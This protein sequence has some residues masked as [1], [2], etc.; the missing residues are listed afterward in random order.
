MLRGVF[1]AGLSVLLLGSAGALPARADVGGPAIVG[2]L[3]AQRAAQGVPAG[4]VESPALSA[5]CAKHNAYG[6]INHLL[7]HQED[8]S[9]PGYTPEG[10]YAAANSVLYQGS[11]PWS[12]SRNPFE[13]APIH[14]HQL[15]APRLDRMGASENQGYGCATTFASRNRPP[16]AADVTYTYPGNGARRWPS[17]QVASESPYTPGQLVGIP[18][19]TRTGPYLYVMFDGPDLTPFDVA[20]AAG[21]VLSGPEGP[22]SVAV[23][24]NKTPGLDG[25]LPTGMQ[26]I[27]RAPLRPGATYTASVAASVTTQGGGGPPRAFSHTW[28]FSTAPALSFAG[29]PKSLRVSKSGRFAYRLLATPGLSGKVKI[30]GRKKVKIGSSKRKMKLGSKSFTA[31]THAK[32]KVRFKLSKR[33]LRALKRHKSLRFAVVVKAGGKTFGAKLKLKRPKRS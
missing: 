24:D 32:A 1:A 13:S 16:P 31:S 7:A 28:S 25:Y 21:A 26:V 14:L 10:N 20:T 3:N 19:D 27:P 17:A 33:N 18:A 4:I 5:A 9:R 15:L 23:V 30:T 29:S 12:A 11:G 22:V 6:A 8:P 2:H